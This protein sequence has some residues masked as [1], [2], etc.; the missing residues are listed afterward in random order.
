M[1]KQAQDKLWNDLSQESQNKLKEMAGLNLREGHY[2]I[3][4]F[5]KLF[6]YHNL[7]PK[8]PVKEWKDVELSINEDYCKLDLALGSI[9]PNYKDD[10]LRLK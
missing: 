4:D 9:L 3:K 8:P 2:L 1:D 6:G 10:K 7:N 5:E